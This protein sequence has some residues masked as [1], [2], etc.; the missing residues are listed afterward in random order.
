M[1]GQGQR[2][3]LLIL[4]TFSTPSKIQECLYDK[5][6][7]DRWQRRGPD[8]RSSHH[9]FG[10]SLVRLRALSSLAPGKF[11]PPGQV[12]LQASLSG[13]R[14]LH[15][16]LCSATQTLAVPLQGTERCD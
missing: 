8:H 15:M 16:E 4:A 11:A 5:S 6:R 7:T 9:R 3:H 1:R 10:C 2:V 12:E 14:C 13:Q